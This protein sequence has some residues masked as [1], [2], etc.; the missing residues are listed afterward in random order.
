MVSVTEVIQAQRREI[1][2]CWTEEATRTAASRG[3]KAPELLDIVPACLDLLTTR[4]DLVTRRSRLASDLAA[5]LRQGFHLAQV[6]EEFASLGRCITRMWTTEPPRQRPD[7]LEVE[8]L[9]TELYSM[10]AA[11][12]DVFVERLVEDERTEKRYLRLIQ[13]VASEAL[14]VDSVAF[15]DRLKE[16][17]TLVKESMGAGGAALLLY[18]PDARERVTV[19]SVGVAEEPWLRFM[20]ASGPGPAMVPGP[21]VTEAVS[22]L[23]DAHPRG[24]EARLLQRE[25]IRSLLGVRL[26]TRHA[27]VGV[28]YVGITTAR[29]FTGRERRRLESLGERLTVHLDNAKLHADL[30]QQVGELQVERDLRERF[31]SVLAHD[32]R[33]PLSSAKLSAQ[34][35]LRNPERL[36]ERRDLAVRIDQNIERADRMV[37]NLL[38]ANRIRAGERLPLRL[39][40]C[41]LGRVALE[42]VEE[43][44]DLH[45]ERFVLRAEEQVRGIWSVDELRRALWNLTNN[46]VKYG[47]PAT[48]ITVTVARTPTG[49]MAS[50]HNEGPAIPVADQESIFKPFSRTHSARTGPSK[51][52][53]L[54]LTLVWGCAQAHGGRVSVTSDARHGTTFILE[55]PLDAR[56]YQQ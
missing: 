49:A 30:Q 32:L 16:V 43:M 54:G 19:I 36:D 14:E 20:S 39:D 8:R 11:A 46:A 31:V 52:W 34:L 37:R 41:D 51:G 21:L 15:K 1:L 3:L 28:M 33:G 48:P 13:E 47:A 12:M 29:E 56:P 40:T 38:D 44:R 50:V 27:L 6:I 9:F 23:L 26:N 35:I 2:R 53:G 42:V 24:E 45:G 10:S 7:S 25:G 22:I 5:R 18:E 4:D 55:L 17:L